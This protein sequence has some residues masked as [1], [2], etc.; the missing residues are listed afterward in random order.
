MLQR[1]GNAVQIGRAGEDVGLAQLLRVLAG[2]ALEL[3]AF[4]VPEYVGAHQH[5]VAGRIAEGHQQIALR[6]QQLQRQLGVSMQRPKNLLK[7]LSGDQRKNSGF[8]AQH[9]K[10][11]Q[12]CV[13]NYNSSGSEWIIL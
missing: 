4:V 12:E 9:L 10:R 6:V 5:T 11:M 7:P 3:G 13:E 8:H 2:L 1:K